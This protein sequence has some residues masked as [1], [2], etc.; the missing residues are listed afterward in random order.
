MLARIIELSLKYRG[1][2]LAAYGVVVAAGIWSLLQLVVDAFPDTTPVMV[3]VNTVAPSLA[4]EEVEQRVTFPIEQTIG[5]LPGLIQL[6]SISKFGLSQVVCVFEDGTD[7][8]RARQWVAERL[9]GLEIGAGVERPQLGPASTGLGEVLHYVVR[10]K[11]VPLD[12]LPEERRIQELL[13]LRTLQ[14]WVIKPRLRAV[15]GTAEVNSWGGYEKCYLVAMDPIRLL[16]YGCTLEEVFTALEGANRNVGGGLLGGR[17]QAV[18]VQG[19]GQLATLDQLGQVV[20]RAEGGV[21]VQ[22]QHVAHLDVGPQL[23]HGAVTYGGQGEA[24]LGLGFMLAGENSHEFTRALKQQLHDIRPQL[25]PDVYVEVLY[26]RTELVDQVLRTVRANLFEGALLVLAVLFLFL[27]SWRAGFVVALVIPLSLL[28]AFTGMAWFG[29]PASL[30]SLGA[31][32]FGLLVDSSVVLV[33]NCFRRLSQ[34]IPVGWRKLDVIRSAAFEVRRPTIFGE[35]II[36]IVF[37]PILT[38]EGTEGKLFR[39]MALTMIFALLGSLILSVTLMPAL[40]GTMLPERIA[41]RET[42]L[43]RLLQAAYRPILHQTIAHPYAVLFAA[44]LLVVLATGWVLPRLGTAFVP[45]LEEGALVL[46][47]VRLAGTDLSESVRANTTIERFLLSE[48]PDEVAHVWSRAGTPEV[49]TDPMGME[50]TD[51]FV[52]LKPRQFWKRAKTQEELEAL[53]QQRMR[54]WPGQRLVMSQPIEMRLNEM[55]SGIRSQVAVKIFGDDYQILKQ[56]AEEV[57]EVLRSVP[58]SSNVTVEQVVGQP[59]L[60]VKLRWNEL[61]RYGIPADEVLQVVETVAGKPVGTV[62]EGQLRFPL[63]VRLAEPYRRDANSLGAVLLRAADGAVVPLS[64]LADLELEEG[65]A[66]ISREWYQRRIVVSCNV[67]GRD[68]GS[69]VREAKQRVAEQVT[70]PP[71]RYWLTW[72]GEYEHYERARAR[73]WVVA[74]MALALVLTLLYVSYGNL[75]DTLRV[76]LGIPFAWTGAILALWLRGMPFSISAAVGFVAV[77]GVAMLADMLLVFTVRQQLAQ[78]KSLTEAVEQA[79]M[80]RLRPVLMT[81]LVASL[82]FLPMA[83]STGVGAEVQRPLATVVIGGIVSSS[84]ASLLVLRALYV[85]LPVRSGT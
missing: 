29:I 54:E 55:I 20:L 37:L 13:R 59:L 3:H 34:G 2:L 62:M 56:K 76:A 16:G 50:V 48:F 51:V 19:V 74:S 8:Y 66:F 63:V 57:A 73:L 22:L 41:P 27:G 21:P 67:R 15:P 81:A 33:E 65:L 70:L 36:M 84:I 58:G 40:A 75:V 12:S 45:R 46:N 47:I 30:F 77:A 24:V 31:I 60:R 53:I 35:L 38:L 78:G 6:R 61:A 43:V 44:G 25:P 80:E 85:I 1:L 79:A 23:R 32:D 72:G 14:D 11:N 10:L 5:G 4:P 52:T 69:F 82:G 9:A 18:L 28:F 26:D 39:P 83:L 7:L 49:A 42:L 64:R 17:G 68:L 71:E